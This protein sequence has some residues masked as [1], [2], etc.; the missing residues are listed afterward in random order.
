MHNNEHIEMLSTKSKY[1]SN[2]LC[3]NIFLGCF[4]LSKHHMII[5]DHHMVRSDVRYDPRWASG[6]FTLWAF[7]ISNTVYIHSQ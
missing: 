4:G 5:S 1:K 2:S 6:C 7:T 3:L